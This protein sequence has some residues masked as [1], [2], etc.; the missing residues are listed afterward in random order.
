MRFLKSC[1][2][3]VMML[4]C[5]P[6]LAQNSEYPTLDALAAVRVPS[7]GYPAYHADL[8]AGVRPQY[9]PTYRKNYL[10]GDRASFYLGVRDGEPPA[11]VETELRAKPKAY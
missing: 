11:L 10:I 8:A 3:V 1:S 6:A 2:L 4:L 9:E 7:Y 5:L